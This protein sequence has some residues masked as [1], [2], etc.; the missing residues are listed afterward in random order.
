VTRGRNAKYIVF[1]AILAAFATLGADKSAPQNDLNA[2]A[3]DDAQWVMP[4]KN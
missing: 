2:L 4:A 3:A 1:W